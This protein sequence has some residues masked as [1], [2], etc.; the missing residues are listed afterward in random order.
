[1]TMTTTTKEKEAPKG[2]M[3][4][5]PDVEGCQV[6][7]DEDTLDAQSGQPMQHHLA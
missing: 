4:H 1:M 7:C 3:T 2:G 5:F 6:Q